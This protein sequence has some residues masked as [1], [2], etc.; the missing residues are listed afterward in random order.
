MMRLL[1]SLCLAIF[2]SALVA[3]AQDG[4]AA[5]GP[6]PAMDTKSAGVIG[7]YA[8]GMNIGQDLKHQ[9]VAVDFDSVIAGIR[10][11]LQGGPPKYTEPQLR[12][13]FEVLQHDMQAKQ[14]QAGDKNKQDAEAFLA[15]NKVKPGVVTLPSGL[16][17]QVLRPG[18]GPSPKATDT[19]KVHYEGTLLN[20][21]VF[22][23]SIKRGEP[24]KFRVNQVIRGWTEALQLMKV[25]DK[26]RLF[27]PPD[28]AYGPRGMGPI[29]PNSLLIFEVELLGIVEPEAGK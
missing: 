11:G 25:G 24:A 21:T 16:Q 23:S 5:G 14:A 4:P 12:A 28:V 7:G 13:A 6:P 29:P 9:G 19:V 2:L 1:G 3:R 8:I 20:G 15:Q 17:Y 10:D 22:D 27:I 26:W 18:N